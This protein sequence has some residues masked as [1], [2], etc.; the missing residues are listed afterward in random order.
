FEKRFGLRVVMS[1]GLT[2]VGVPIASPQDDRCPGSSGRALPD[3][4]IRLVDDDDEDVPVGEVGE[5]VL[6]PLKSFTTSLGYWCKPEATV[7]A[8]QNLWS[9]TC[10]LMRLDEDGWYSFGDRKKDSI[11]HAGENISSA[12]VE[13]AMVE[14]EAVAEAAVYAVPSALGE[15]DV[16][17]SV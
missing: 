4:E 9:H 7:A 6:R 8:W 2:D 3:W 12:E 14:H 15:D 11:R 17:A 16:M 13:M 1:Y 10:D 5:I